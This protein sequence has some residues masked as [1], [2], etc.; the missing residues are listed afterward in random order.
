VASGEGLGL[1][2]DTCSCK[3]IVHDRSLMLVFSAITCDTTEATLIR[4][5]AL[6]TC[7]NSAATSS[8]RLAPAKDSTVVINELHAM[9]ATNGL[10]LTGLMEIQI[11]DASSAKRCRLTSR[12]KGDTHKE[13]Q[14]K[15]KQAHNSTWGG[16]VN[17]L[18]HH[19]HMFK[20]EAM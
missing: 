15:S 19:Q 4:G 13:S 17:H 3:L 18:P 20:D 10:S 14:L 16:D 9:I 6:H 11:L 5:S 7:V 2:S 12:K 1:Y 8:K